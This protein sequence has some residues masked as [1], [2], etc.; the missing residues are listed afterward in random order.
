M[1]SIHDST[2][3]PARKN[4]GGLRAAPTPAGVPV[5]ITSPGRS[6]STLEQPSPRSSGSVELVDRDDPRTHRSEAAPRLAQSELPAGREL[7]GAIAAVLRARGCLQTTR[8]RGVRV[9]AMKKILVLLVVV[10][11]VALA[12]KKVRTV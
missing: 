7:Q 12:A 5:K 6:E 8:G 9:A 10:G 2:T 3:W 4:F 1:P 11:L